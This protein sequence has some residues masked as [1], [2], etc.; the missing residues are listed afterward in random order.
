VPEQNS[1]EANPGERYWSQASN[2]FQTD[3]GEQGI[4]WEQA[5]HTV[6]VPN[7]VYV[8]HFYDPYDFTANG[9]GSFDPAALE[10]AVKRRVE[11]A[12][13]HGP[14]P[15]IVTEYGITRANAARA[16][17]SWLDTVH[18]L[19]GAYGISSTYWVYKGPIG[20]DI[21]AARGFFPVWGEWVT[22]PNEIEV[23]EGRYRFAPWAR[24]R[25][26][27]NQFTQLVDAYFWKDGAV[28]SPSLLDNGSVLESL[29]AHWK[30]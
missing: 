1:R 12:E 23:S 24:E 19:F 22:W 30:R 9:E 28:V 4:V 3:R 14:F 6:D 17:A 13:K 26:E 8:F 5:F 11:W 7:V 20:V 18:G 10:A 2:G 16:R 29:R 27:K 25:A 21:D 15:L